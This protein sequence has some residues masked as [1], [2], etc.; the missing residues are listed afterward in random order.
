MNFLKKYDREI[1]FLNDDEQ[2]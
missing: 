1:F 2:F